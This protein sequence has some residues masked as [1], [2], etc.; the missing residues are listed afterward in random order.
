MLRLYSEPSEDDM[1]WKRCSQ[2]DSERFEWHGPAYIVRQVVIFEGAGLVTG[3]TR[4]VKVEDA[5]GTIHCAECGYRHQWLKGVV[6][7]SERDDGGDRAC[8]GNCY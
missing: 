6:I 1:D 3:P 8:T 5:K 2:C 4:V 7:E